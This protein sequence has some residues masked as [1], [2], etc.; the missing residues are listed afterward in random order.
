M[1]KFKILINNK[2]NYSLD[3][4][5]KCPLSGRYMIDPV[6]ASDGYTYE[7]NELLEYLK[8]NN[9]SPVNNCKLSLSMRENFCIQD[10]I[11]LALN[12]MPNEKE[13]LYNK[14]VIYENIMINQNFIEESSDF[15]LKK[16][17]DNSIHISHI[18]EH[19]WCVGHLICDFSNDYIINYFFENI[20]YNPDLLTKDGENYLHLLCENDYLNENNK[21]LNVLSKNIDNLKH[22][23]NLKDK[24]GRYCVDNC[25]IYTKNVENL[26]FLINHG[27]KL[28]NICENL[29]KN[30]NLSNEVKSEFINKHFKNNTDVNKYI[31]DESKNIFEQITK[32]KNNNSNEN[33]EVEDEIK[34]K[35]KKNSRNS[36]KI[37]FV[38]EDYM[39]KNEDDININNLKKCKSSSI[40]KFLKNND[41]KLS[42]MKKKELC[43]KAIEI[44]LKMKKEKK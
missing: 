13:Y 36:N 23:I 3:E 18:D 27:S 4:K 24:R 42:K 6:L 34:E 29:S 10:I 21:L 28:E 37:D 19:E 8:H 17:L 41:I 35:K 26:E 11:E 32:N 7:K 15:L 30:N 2:M 12:M 20:K 33:E 25:A 43:E 16:V 38:I 22:L 9:I 31:V 14:N 40:K 44:I 1:Y 5:L 39:N